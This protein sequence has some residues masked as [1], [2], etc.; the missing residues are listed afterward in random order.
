M[1][2]VNIFE[3]TANF[4]IHIF[5]MDVFL[6]EIISKYAVLL[7]SGLFIGFTKT[8]VN[9]CLVYVYTFRKRVRS[10]FFKLC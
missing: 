10:S 9:F 6:T 8:H 4:I 3:K 1:A 5:P 2:Q 7:T